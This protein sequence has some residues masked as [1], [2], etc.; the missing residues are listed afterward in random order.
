MYYMRIWKQ[1]M[2]DGRR[3]TRC[4]FAM[5]LTVLFALPVVSVFADPPPESRLATLWT[6]LLDSSTLEARAAAL[7]ISGVVDIYPQVGIELSPYVVEWRIVVDEDALA[8][9]KSWGSGA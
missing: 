7:S 9:I 3:R 1:V 2:S 5:A 4:C 6:S 8:K